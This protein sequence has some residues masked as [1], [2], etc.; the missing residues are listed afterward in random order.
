MF[1]IGKAHHLLICSYQLPDDVF[2]PGEARPAKAKKGKGGKNAEAAN[3]KRTPAEAELDVSSTENVCPSPSRMCTYC[4]GHRRETRLKQ[5][6]D[7][8]QTLQQRTAY[9]TA[10]HLQP[11]SRLE[12]WYCYF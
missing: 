11:E 12:A 1:A 10:I 3:R 4:R 6:D 5:R 8:P 9:Q 2:E 7:S